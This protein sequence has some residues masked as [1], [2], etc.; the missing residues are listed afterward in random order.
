VFLFLKRKGGVD[1]RDVR[2]WGKN[3]S[4]GRGNCGQEIK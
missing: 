2:E 3:R 4:G 1:E